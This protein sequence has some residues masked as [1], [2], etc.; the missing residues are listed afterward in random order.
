M[1]AAPRS[2][3]DIRPLPRPDGRRSPV[4]AAW[5]TRPSPPHPCWRSCCRRPA[6][7][8]ATLSFCCTRRKAAAR[9]ASTPPAVLPPAQARPR[10]MRR[11]SSAGYCPVRRR[12]SSPDGKHCIAALV[13]CPGAISSPVRSSSRIVASRRLPDWRRPPQPTVRCWSRT[14]ARRSFFS[15]TGRSSPGCCSDNRSSPPR[16][17]GSRTAARKRSIAARPPPALRATCARAAAGSMR[18]TLPDAPPTG[19]TRSK[20]AIAAY[21]CA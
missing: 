16:S 18:T 14:R 2:S 4:A 21:A 17:T 15:A 8:E 7:S 19:S 10:S 20:P 5:R 12:V 9:S 13:V 1:V 11:S 3:V 6:R